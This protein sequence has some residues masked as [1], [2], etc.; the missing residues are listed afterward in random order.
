M[1]Y[2]II[3][4][5]HANLDA[6][7]AVREDIERQ[8]GVDEVWCLGDVVGYGPEPGECIS[9]LR[10]MTDVCVAGNHDWAATEKLGTADFN[11]DA[12]AA[13]RWTK[14]QLDPEGIEYLNSLPLVTEKGDF[15]LAH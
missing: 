2:A 15:T 11:P 13:A 6:F 8:G 5:I 9:L 12:A 14:Q 10:Q 4:D 3:A 7:N 1:R